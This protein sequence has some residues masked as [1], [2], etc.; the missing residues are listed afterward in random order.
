M[1]DKKILAYIDIACCLILFPAMIMFMPVEYWFPDS[2]MFVML[3]VAWLYCVYFVNR[4]IC[5]PLLFMRRRVVYVLL[6]V[7]FSLFVTYL[8]IWY[9]RGVSPLDDPF[10]NKSIGRMRRLSVWFI[11]FMVFCF[12]FMIGMLIELHRQAMERQSI[13]QG[14]RNAELA[15]YKAQ[16]DPHFLFN[17][18]NTLYGLVVS[19]SEKTEDAIVKFSGLMRYMYVNAARDKVSMKEEVG[20]ISEY[21][22]LQRLRL[23][24]HTRID[25]SCRLDD[26]DLEIA[27]MILMTF[28]EN[29]FKYGTSSH[30]DSE[31]TISICVSDGILSL[32]VDNMVMRRRLTDK[33]GIGIDN[34]RKRLELLY[35]GAY[36]LDITNADDRY[37]VAL[38]IELKKR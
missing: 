4:K 36:R 5:T 16:I 31:I 20:Y 8:M 15:L 10:V 27:P 6:W 38:I 29:A 2:P 9:S 3:I 17:T 12:S 18:L 11:Y 1:V 14:K 28:V 26:N 35:P 25:F 7:V 22:E 24:G 21:I 34:C 32:S 23:N 13:E 19:Q 30:F 37:K 33:D